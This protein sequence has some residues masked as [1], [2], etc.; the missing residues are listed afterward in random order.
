MTFRNTQRLNS[1]SCIHS[2][3]SE[4][5]LGPTFETAELAEDI[6]LCIFSCTQ[7]DAAISV[8]LVV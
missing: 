3:V 8:L 7:T 1:A 5:V 2:F 6:I 4:N